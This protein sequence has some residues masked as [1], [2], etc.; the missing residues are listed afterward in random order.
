MKELWRNKWSMNIVLKSKIEMFEG[1]ERM[2]YSSA[3]IIILIEDNNKTSNAIWKS[4]GKQ[5][6]KDSICVEVRSRKPIH[7]K[8]SKHEAS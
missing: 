2:W 3:N 8:K 1:N 4:K 6:T 5:K 7:M